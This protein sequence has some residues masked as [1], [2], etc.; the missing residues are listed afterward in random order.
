VQVSGRMTS[1]PV[2]RVKG[3]RAAEGRKGKLR[4]KVRERRRRRELI[5]QME[6]D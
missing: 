4:E 5:E 2:S 6:R 3:N 1:D